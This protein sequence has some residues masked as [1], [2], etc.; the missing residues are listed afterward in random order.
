MRGVRFLAVSET[1]Q[2]GKFNEA[3]IRR[4]TGDDL[5]TARFMHK[6]FSDFTQTH[7]AWFL[8]NYKLQISGRDEAVWSRPKLIEFLVQFVD[9]TPECPEPKHRKDHGLKAQLKSE[10]E[11]VLAWVIEG[12]REWY[13]RRKQNLG[14][15]EP[16]CVRGAVAKY[17]K[18]EDQLRHF[19]DECIE[20]TG[21]TPI[22]VRTLKGL[23][24]A[25]SRVWCR[26]RGLEPW[27][28]KGLGILLAD[29]GF[30]EDREDN[31]RYWGEVALKKNWEQHG[32]DEIERLKEARTGPRG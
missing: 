25:A 13:E 7:H 2:G 29:A 31:A 8:S 28:S 22:G 21:A 16:Q 11:G 19:L 23:M 30:E 4:M 32:F 18:D 15:E 26:L 27:S 1:S 6:N 20:V 24:Y 12:A 5:I 9:P 10:I 3:R 14:I 17:R